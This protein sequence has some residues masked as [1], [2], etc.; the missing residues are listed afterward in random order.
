MSYCT[1]ISLV[2]V[3]L[4]TPLV[5]LLEPWTLNLY[6]CSFVCCGGVQTW[7]HVEE[8]QIGVSWSSDPFTLD[9]VIY[10]THMSKS[11]KY[12]PRS[13]IYLSNLLAYN[14]CTHCYTW[15]STARRDNARL[16]QSISN[17][18]I[19]RTLKGLPLLVCINL[20]N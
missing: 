7:S 20:S 18:W 14:N 15:T 13:N 4:L 8:Q 17:S 12:L 3:N 16:C 6:T 19:I 2:L 10:L 9:C 11:S 1:V 5:L